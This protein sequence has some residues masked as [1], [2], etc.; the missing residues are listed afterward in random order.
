MSEFAA[1]SRNPKSVSPPP[2]TPPVR[3]DEALLSQQCKARRLFGGLPRIIQAQSPGGGIPNASDVHRQ[4]QYVKVLREVTSG[5]SLG[6]AEEHGS[7]QA[8]RK[9]E[10]SRKHFAAGLID[11]MIA[12]KLLER[13]EERGVTA[14]AEGRRLFNRLR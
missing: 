11:E 1:S 14:T 3:Y 13:D 6:P 10:L 8:V 9:F 4:Q 12:A 7:N 5:D 2:T